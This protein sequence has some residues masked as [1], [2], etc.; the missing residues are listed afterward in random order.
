[1]SL[2]EP[3]ATRGY[4][5]SVFA[6][7]PRLLERAGPGPILP[8]GGAGQVTGLF[9]VLVEGDDH[10][11]PVA[12][13]VR[14]ILDGHITMDRKIAEAGRYPAIDILRSLSRVAA[15]CLDEAQAAMVRRARAVLS[16]HGEMVDMVRLGAY[17]PGTDAA[18]DEAL[19]LTPAIEDFLRQAPGDRSGFEESFER[20]F[21]ALGG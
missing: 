2:G 21:R 6:E 5:P 19:R 4:P 3:P 11:E 7:L 13:A 1:L 14:G 20:L 16:L 9:T 10:N 18:V 17:R 8:G 15:S 12:D